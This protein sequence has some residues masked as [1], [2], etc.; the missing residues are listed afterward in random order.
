MNSVPCLWRTCEERA[1]VAWY[2]F[3]IRTFWRNERSK[4]WSGTRGYSDDKGKLNE[5]I[6]R[7]W[8]DRRID[9]STVHLRRVTLPR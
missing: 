3:R 2:K 8:E 1:R 9:D 6:N 7:P 5:E 4:G